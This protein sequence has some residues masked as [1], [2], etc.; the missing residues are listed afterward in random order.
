[1][2]QPSFRD[3]ETLNAYL[4]GQLDSAHRQ[5]LES[6]LQ[7]EPELKAALDAL[8][9]S[10]SVLRRLPQRRA[11]RN[12]TLTPKMAGIKPPLPR[13]YPIFRFA[14]VVA[15]FLFFFAY[16]T[17]FLPRL[18]LTLGAAAPAV[19]TGKGGGAPEDNQRN[20][21]GGGC[22]SC[23]VEA[24]IQVEA[25]LAPSE[26]VPPSALPT[27]TPTAE[28]EQSF[29]QQ[30]PSEVGPAAGTGRP[31]FTVPAPTL[32]QVVLFVL[33][34]LAGGVAL[35]IRLGVERR[36]AKAHAIASRISWRDVLLF[37]LALL[38]IAAALWGLVALS[39]G[40]LSFSSVQLPLVM[41]PTNVPA[42]AGQKGGVSPQGNK[43][44]NFSGQPAIFSLDPSMGYGYTYADPQGYII[45]L[46]FPAGTF[47][48]PTDLQF[49]VGQGA[50]TPEGY[51]FAGRGFQVYTISESLPLRKPVNVTVF[52]SDA[53][54]SLVPDEN[55][56]LLMFW[57]GSGW[58][59]AATLCSP[60][61][62][63]NRSPDGNML[64]LDVCDI[65][66]F[67]LFAPLK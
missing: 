25:P 58:V 39:S 56:L 30:A 64:W 23:T 20:Q 38:L 19:E 5:R 51:T 43:G 21:S 3:V 46:V 8:R 40:S 36:W 9:E 10:R 2:T 6:R 18:T 22:D 11:P 13:A 29:A 52:Y 1:M 60:A 53:D 63:V 28:T 65:G 7:S 35:L 55:Q 62:E 37:G 67:A 31:S 59:D 4:D 61:S 34:C 66:G 45:A 24:T 33:A 16:A 26:K 44:G 49:S 12:F 27:P 17:N 41:I 47:D 50:P 14:S 48:M 54:V 42:E 32:W 57:N 15:A